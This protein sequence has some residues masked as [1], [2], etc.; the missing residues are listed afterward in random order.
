MPELHI[1]EQLKF[2]QLSDVGGENERLPKEDL[3]V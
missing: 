3:G 2:K 1:Y